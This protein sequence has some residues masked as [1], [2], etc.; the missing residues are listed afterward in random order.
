L[1]FEFS[2]N[3]DDIFKTCQI[4][5]KSN[6]KPKGAF[7][8][9]FGLLSAFVFI[10][11]F[12]HYQSGGQQG[13]VFLF[14]GCFIGL[15]YSAI[16]LSFYSTQGQNN[17]NLNSDGMI[18]SQRKLTISDKGITQGNSKYTTIYYWGSINNI[19]ES[20]EYIIVLLDNLLFQTI[21]KSIFSEQNL[22][23]FIDLITEYY[24]VPKKLMSSTNI[25]KENKG[26]GW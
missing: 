4:I 19:I 21:P 23:D 12:N 9:L 3:K 22:S 20:D 1:E 13:L 7:V 15:V 11:G 6:K 2:L 10:Y 26:E 14:V 16:L 5:Q 25:N 24:G 18:L 8:K 17:F